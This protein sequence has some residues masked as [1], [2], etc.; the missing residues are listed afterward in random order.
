MNLFASIPTFLRLPSID[1]IFKYPFLKRMA[2]PG[3]MFSCL[4]TL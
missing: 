1:Y 2:H 3:R 4:A